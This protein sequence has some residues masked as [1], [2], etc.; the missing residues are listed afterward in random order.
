MLKVNRTYYVLRFLVVLYTTLLYSLLNIIEQ[1][2]LDA[3]WKQETLCSPVFS[4]TLLYTTLLYCL[5]AKGKQDTHCSPVFS[6][7]LLYSLFKMIEQNQLDA[8]WKQETL[9]SPVFSGTLLYTTLLYC[10][11]AKGKQDTHCSP[12]FSG[13]LLYSTLYSK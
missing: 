3:K 9:C 10:L 7:T 13:T 12:V 11:D 4:G 1:N 2:Q 8:K 6:G 5:D